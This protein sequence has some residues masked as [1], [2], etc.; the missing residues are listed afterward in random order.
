MVVSSNIATPNITTIMRKFMN[1][2][3][4]VVTILWEEIKF[5][6]SNL[7][8][9]LTCKV[10]EGKNVEK[11]F[12]CKKNGG[13]KRIEGEKKLGVKKIGCEK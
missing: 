7:N 10:Y 4:V 6:P 12:G 13:T 5:C 11:K 9:F 3:T 2:H 1:P 8:Y